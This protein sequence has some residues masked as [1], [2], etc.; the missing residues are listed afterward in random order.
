[1]AKNDTE[2]IIKTLT[3]N[4]NKALDKALADQRITFEKMLREKDDEIARLKTNKNGSDED[5]IEK[6]KK[7]L[8]EKD[9]E[10]SEAEKVDNEKWRQKYLKIDWMQEFLDGKTTEES[11]KAAYKSNLSVFI[12]YCSDTLH[13]EIIDI[14][15][16]DAKKYAASLS[17]LKPGSQVVKLNNI[18]DFYGF[19]LLW[20]TRQRD[21][22]GNLVRCPPVVPFNP[23][24]NVKNPDYDFRKYGHKRLTEDELKEMLEIA[25]YQAP[26]DYFAIKAYIATGS[27]ISALG[28][29][30]VDDIEWDERRVKVRKA[31]KGAKYINLP[32]NFMPILENYVK[33]QK[34][35]PGDKLFPFSIGTLRQHIEKIGRM[36]GIKDTVNPHRL[37]KSYASI[38]AEQGVDRTYIKNQLNHKTGIM[39]DYYIQADEKKQQTAIDE[40]NPLTVLE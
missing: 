21:K 4:F 20:N 22:G 38:A 31:G 27:R 1:M 24:D 35:K 25:K 23:F 16:V 10:A 18:R 5:I 32:K 2:L 39:T 30:H 29:A 17:G 34:L 9:K 13:K 11:T 15:E 8:S 40:G 3:D 26:V 6:L 12:K 33:S 36:A 37:R 7:A 14:N 19:L 28:E